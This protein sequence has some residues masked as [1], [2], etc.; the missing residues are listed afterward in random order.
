[1]VDPFFLVGVHRCHHLHRRSPD[2][3]QSNRSDSGFGEETALDILKK[4][5]AKGEITKEQFEQMKR[6]IGA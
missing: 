3:Q 6:D 5:Y 4:R 2:R 1:V